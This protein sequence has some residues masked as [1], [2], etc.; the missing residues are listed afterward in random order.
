ME[1]R[2]LLVNLKKP[3]SKGVMFGHHDV[4][5]YG[6]GWKYG[7]GRSDVNKVTGEYPAVN[8][9]DYSGLEKEGGLLNIDGV[10]FEKMR[11]YIK[12]G[13]ERGGV[14]TVSWHLNNPLNGKSARDTTQ[15]GVAAALPGGGAS[16]EYMQWLDRMAGFTLSLRGS[17][18]ELIPILVRPFHELTGFWFWWTKNTNTPDQFKQLWKYTVDYLRNTKTVHNLIPV[19]NTASFNSR[20]QFLERYPG[21]DYVDMIG[22]DAYQYGD[23]LKNNNFVDELSFQLNM[24]YT[25]AIELKKTPAL[26]ET[27]YEAIPYPEWRTKTL[28]KTIE[29][30]PLSYVLL[31]RNAGLQENGNM[32]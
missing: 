23:P 20:A 8:G 14:I 27:G 18:N 11:Q 10:P 25:L 30:H 3:L 1:T 7:A 9:W 16:G 24:L 17:K 6:V 4:L 21:D 22:F 5:A 28:W 2:N 12:Q 15:G 29:G 32:H 19:Y 13:F 31:W 26:G